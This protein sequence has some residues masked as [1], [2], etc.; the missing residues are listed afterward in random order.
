MDIG[1]NICVKELFQK[2]YRPSLR[3]LG[4]TMVEDVQW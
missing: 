1:R 4:K 2:K 3:D